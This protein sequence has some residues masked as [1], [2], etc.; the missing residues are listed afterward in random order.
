MYRWLVGNLRLWSV[1]ELMSSV[2][3]SYRERIRKNI[4]NEAVKNLDIIMFNYIL[5]SRLL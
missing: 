3:R 1:Q 2:Y 4:H 5:S